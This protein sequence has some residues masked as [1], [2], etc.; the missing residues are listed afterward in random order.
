LR[1]TIIGRPAS[2]KSTLTDGLVARSPG[3]RT[4]GVR[5]HFTKEVEAGTPIGLRVSDIVARHGWIPDEL[6]I[7]AVREQI[8]TGALGTSFILEGM[9][10]N[11]RQAE[12]LDEL[13]AE[14]GLPLHGAVHVAT[15][16]DVCSA[17]AT[18]RLVCYHCDGG[19]HEA[20]RAGDAM[21][22]AG[23]GRPVTPRES[24]AEEL[25]SAR[26]TQYRELG[27]ALVGYYA[28]DRLLELDGRASPDDGCAAVRAFVARRST[29]ADS[30]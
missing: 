21:R 4:F 19:S 25:F 10:G 2:G 22:C 13:L 5:R 1:I 7:S 28:G 17:R 29:M 16:E 14:L 30:V 11:V 18:R 8:S 27:R 26:L 12:L 24:D 23:C 9:P 6:V 15:P 20:V 3:L